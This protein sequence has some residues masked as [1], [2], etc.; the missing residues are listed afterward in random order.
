MSYNEA[1][2]R[3][4]LIDPVLRDKGYDDHSKL[5]PETPAP[6]HAQAV[7]GWR[8]GSQKRTGRPAQR[9]ATGQGILPNATVLAFS[10]YLPPTAIYTVNT[11][12]QRLAN[13]AA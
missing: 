5:K 7:T 13:R 1:E 8:T 11:I 3:Y 4:Y 6:V 9:H 12:N 10:M 2:P